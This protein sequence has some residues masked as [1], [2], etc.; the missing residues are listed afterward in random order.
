MPRP[1]SP[2]ARSPL[3]RSLPSHV[4]LP[5]PRAHSSLAQSWRRERESVV[6]AA[7]RAKAKAAG[8]AEVGAAGED[9]AAASAAAAAA[10]AARELA[11]SP[12]HAV[13]LRAITSTLAA[14]ARVGRCPPSLL[15]EAGAAAAP[16]L[17]REATPADVAGLAYA[18]SRANVRAPQIFN[19]LAARALRGAIEPDSAAGA[20]LTKRAQQQQQQ[21]QQPLDDFKEPELASLALSFSSL[22]TASPALFGAIAARVAARRFQTASV[23]PHVL[24]SLA[25]AFARSIRLDGAAAAPLRL[26]LARGAGAA[27]A[28]GTA[29]AEASASSTP[30]PPAPPPPPSPP[31]R[32][33]ASI[34]S[35]FLQLL[36]ERFEGTARSHRVPVVQP[37]AFTAQV[38]AEA[39]PLP[40]ALALALSLAFAL[41]RPCARLL[42]TRPDH[43]F[44]CPFF[45]ASRPRRGRT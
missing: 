26:R 23:T 25:T 11:R 12:A 42:L 38:R 17:A 21:K 24:A 22:R 19:K 5:R 31:P 39:A 3:T 40:S 29:G 16:R 44:R 41:S 10:A 34:A 14:L 28:K 32:S 13:G 6:A 9:S 45:R 43:L 7:A 15:H 35:E 20:Q 18:F 8:G 27:G 30:P 36:G 2:L 1:F 4:P 33:H 37:L